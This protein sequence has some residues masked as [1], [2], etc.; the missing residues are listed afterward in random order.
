MQYLFNFQVKP[1]PGVESTP[2]PLVVYWKTDNNMTDYRLDYRY[3]PSAMSTPVTIKNVNVAVP[4]EGEL[5]KMQSIP[6]GHRYLH[7]KLSLISLIPTGHSLVA[8]TI[9]FL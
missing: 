6:N 3:N 9:V 2:L 1:K 4:V 5:V 8:T 7:G